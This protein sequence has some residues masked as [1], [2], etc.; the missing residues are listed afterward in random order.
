M[1]NMAEIN[2]GNDEAALQA[3]YSAILDL[4]AVY[5]S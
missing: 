4:V 3:I 5:W 2:F 1:A